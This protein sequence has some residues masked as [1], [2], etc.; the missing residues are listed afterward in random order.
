MFSSYKPNG[1]KRGTVNSHDA[2][3]E[4]KLRKSTKLRICICRRTDKGELVPLTKFTHT[5]PIKESQFI[6]SG[7]MEILFSF[8]DKDK[9]SSKDGEVIPKNVAERG[10]K[11]GSATSSTPSEEEGKVERYRALFV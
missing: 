8:I 2:I 5:K 4:D 10:H 11:K 6:T 1:K 3:A 7:M 9:E